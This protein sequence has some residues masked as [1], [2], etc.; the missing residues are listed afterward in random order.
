[1]GK[2]ICIS[3][4]RMLFLLAYAL[5]FSGLIIDHT[6]ALYSSEIKRFV[7]V[8]AICCLI[9][10]CMKK[11]MD[12]MILKRKIWIYLILLAVTVLAVLSNDLFLL[13]LILLGIS[14][15]VDCEGVIKSIY[16]ISIKLTIF[17]S[18]LIV[19]L[20]L[21][22]V[23]PNLS[24]IRS[25]GM[26][27]RWA[28]GFDHSQTLSLLFL[29]VVLY[30]YTYK[31]K[32]SINDFILFQ[33]IGWF[34]AFFFDT[35]NG[36]YSLEIF[37]FIYASFKM[38]CFTFQRNNKLI[39]KILYFISCRIIGIIAILSFVVLWFYTRGNALIIKMDSILTGRISLPLR[40]FSTHPI[41]W[42]NI[43]SFN[44][45]RSA[46]ESTMD[47]GYY[48]IAFRYGILYLILLC[49]ISRFITKFFRLQNN[50]F[51]AISFITIAISCAVANGFPGCYFYP[52]WIVA[53]YE[54]KR[55]SANHIKTIQNRTIKAGGI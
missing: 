37:Y 3:K 4:K 34:L 36:L 20:C 44:E 13:F 14:I 40:T 24:S 46:L 16:K 19:I 32:V 50:I 10:V 52:F 5:Y 42:I 30:Y 49:I 28:Y 9:P 53:I 8:I 51:G 54:V 35:R 18:T 55:S 43:M 25:I 7:S 12:F 48:Y 29:Y 1:M 15:P 39:H 38:L 17:I 27:D 31:Q 22:D 26:N 23:I 33:L 45:Y 6:V 41:K 11:R 47:N 21:A 2:T